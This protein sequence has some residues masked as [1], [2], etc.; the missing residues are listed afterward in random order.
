MSSETLETLNVLIVGVGGQGSV[1]AAKLLARLAHDRGWAV[2]T[3]ETIGMAQRGGSVASHVRMAVDPALLDARSPLM[4]PGGAD[5]MIAFEPGE[6]LRNL[7]FLAPT[8]RLIT[9]TTPL[10]PA[11]CADGPAYDRATLIDALRV[12]FTHADGNATCAD[13]AIVENV[14]NDGAAHRLWLVDDETLLREIGNRRCLNTALIS[15]AIAANLLPFNQEELEAA[16]VATVKPKLIEVNRQAVA[17]AASF[18]LKPARA[19]E[20]GEC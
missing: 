10:P 19:E 18:P 15:C 4:P 6:A 7:G 20:S 1:L 2:R 17:C 16:I 9:A 3:A 14:A 13:V 5:V 8:G 12:S 11:G